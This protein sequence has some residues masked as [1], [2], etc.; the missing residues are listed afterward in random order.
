MNPIRLFYGHTNTYF[1]DGLLVDTDLPGTMPAFR[2]ALKQNGIA[3]GDIR[4]L[5]S[6]HY[7]PD[8]M[9]LNGEL[10][11]A[12]VRL[13]V[14]DRQLPHIHFSNG[15]FARQPQIPFSPLDESALTVFSCTE[16]RAF[17]ASLGIAGEILPT[18]SHSPDGITLL[19]DD[20]HAFVGDLEPRQFVDGY[21]ADSPLRADWERILARSPRFLHFGHYND[22]TASE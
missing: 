17:L 12:G 7:H 8:H 16:S 10:Q 9:G 2:K 5:L 6:T 11:A 18:E 20:G 1:A 4:F 13:L 21:P 19:L 3:P 22:Q 15:I 14:L